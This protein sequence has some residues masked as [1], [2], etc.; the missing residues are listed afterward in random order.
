MNAL[1]PLLLAA[2]S[3]PNDTK[4][5]P[6]EKAAKDFMSSHGLSD[7][8]PEEVDVDALLQSQFL[9]GRFGAFEIL[10]PVSGL[11]RRAADLKDC[12]SALL[13]AQEKLLDWSKASGKDQKALRADLKTVGDWVKSW[14]PAALATCPSPPRVSC[15]RRPRH[16]AA[17]T[18]S[19]W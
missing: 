8:K 12:A 5:V 13:T 14:R 17:A 4:G 2:L 1:A 3:L 9:H 6:F 16:R 18:G 7:K 15:L 19:A 10:F 11:E